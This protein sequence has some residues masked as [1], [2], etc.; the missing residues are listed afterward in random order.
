MV[1]FM[2]VSL[3]VKE[4]VIHSFVTKFFKNVPTAPAKPMKVII[5]ADNC[6][7]HPFRGSNAA[8]KVAQLMT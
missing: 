7:L 4:L 2:V 6:F 8:L 3:A 1:C 5:D